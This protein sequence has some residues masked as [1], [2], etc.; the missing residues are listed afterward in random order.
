MI[1]EGKNPI[2]QI[3]GVEYIAASNGAFSV[4]PRSYSALAFRIKGTTVITAG[5][6][7]YR[8]QPNDILYMP[9]NLAYKAEYADTQMLVIHFVTEQND[10]CP[11]V[12]SIENA[13]QLCQAFAQAHTLWQTKAQ[14]YGVYTMSQLYHILGL[15]CDRETKLNMPS[16][17][18]AA[19]AYIHGNFKDNALSVGAICKSAGIGQT[20]FRLLFQKYYQKTPVEYII[21]L[22]LECARNQ[23]A[24]GMPVEQAAV[25]SGFN[26]PKYFA[27]TVK[28]RF[29][30]T[31]RDWK[32]YGK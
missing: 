30:C 27:R 28:K 29:G 1:Y 23:I 31:P 4:T 3:V 26:D 22:R 14:G 9:Q 7:Q 15:I 24:S 17:F 2:L 19:I 32:T 10:P 25:D 12:Y 8:L 16:N 6:S 11:E 18:L 5:D 13:Q 21:D 20:N